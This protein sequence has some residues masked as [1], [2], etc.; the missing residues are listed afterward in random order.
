MKTQAKIYNTRISVCIAKQT[1]KEFFL[2]KQENNIILQKRINNNSM[3]MPAGKQMKPAE[4]NKQTMIQLS[5]LGESCSANSGVGLSYFESQTGNSHLPNEC[6]GAATITNYLLP[7]CSPRDA[8]ENLYQLSITYSEP[9][10]KIHFAKGTRHSSVFCMKMGW[11]IK[12]E[13]LPIE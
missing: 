7:T 3:H 11:S 9:I 12:K 1:E 13:G 6:S 4:K 8:L 10:D 2:I 5:L